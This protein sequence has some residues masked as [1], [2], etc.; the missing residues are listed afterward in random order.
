MADPEAGVPEAG[1]LH[2]LLTDGANTRTRRC[3]GPRRMPVQP[4]MARRRPATQTPD[5]GFNA[6]LTARAACVHVEHVTLS[7]CR[8]FADLP[9]H[10]LT[11]AQAAGLLGVHEITVSTRVSK[12]AC[13]RSATSQGQRAAV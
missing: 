7:P 4:T 11:H 1:N 8:R 9:P 12:G 5:A 6:R 3:C 10:R 2:K 13:R